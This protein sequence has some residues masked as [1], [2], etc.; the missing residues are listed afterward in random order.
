MAIQA[1]HQ[2]IADHQDPAAKQKLAAC[3]QNMLAVQQQDMAQ[4]Q[5]QNPI[6]KAL[7]G[8]AA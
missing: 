4:Q 1:L 6:L 7:S 2:A 8:G 3:L 5:N